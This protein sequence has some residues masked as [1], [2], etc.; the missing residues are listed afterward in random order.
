MMMRTSQLYVS[1]D[2]LSVSISHISIQSD[3]E[4]SSEEEEKAAPVAAPAPPKRKGTLK[5]KLAEKE[6]QKAARLEA[7]EEDTDYDSDEV[8]DPREKAKRDKE[9]ELKAD[10]HNAAEL[11]GATA[12][13]GKSTR[14]L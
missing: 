8:L 13:G 14:T 7:E 4:A 5:A 9:R 10:L 2:V 1:F 3:W 12:H 11:F 6:A